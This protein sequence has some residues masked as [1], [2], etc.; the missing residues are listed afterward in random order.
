[1]SNL[2]KIEGGVTIKEILLCVIL[3]LS[4]DCK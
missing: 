2:K 4:P 3:I 1:M